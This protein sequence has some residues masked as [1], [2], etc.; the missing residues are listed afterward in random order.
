MSL[1]A[2]IHGKIFEIHGWSCIEWLAQKR[3]SR[4]HVFLTWS[5]KDIP[6]SKEDIKKT[7]EERI[8]LEIAYIISE[9]SCKDGRSHFHML[10]TSV[11]GSFDLQDKSR[12]DMY[13][14]GKRYSPYIVS[15]KSSADAR[16]VIY[17]LQKEDKTPL[18]KIYTSA[19][20]KCK[21]KSN[22]S[23]SS[24]GRLSALETLSI[25]SESETYGDVL[26]RIGDRA[27]PASLLPTFDRL[28]LEKDSC[29]LSITREPLRPIDEFYVPNVVKRWYKWWVTDQHAAGNGRSKC[30]IITGPPETAKTT[31]LRSLGPHL[32]FSS[33]VT[34]QDFQ[35]ETIIPEEIEYIVIDD[36]SGIFKS[37]N[38]YA[39][40]AKP[41]LNS[42]IDGFRAHLRNLTNVPCL[43]KLPVIWVQNCNKTTYKFWEERDPLD[44]KV[45]ATYVECV[46]VKRDVYKAVNKGF[47]EATSFKD[48]GGTA[49]LNEVIMRRARDDKIDTLE[50]IYGPYK[51]ELSDFYSFSK[52]TRK[53]RVQT[54]ADEHKISYEY[55]VE[56]IY[57]GIDINDFGVFVQ[58]ESVP[59]ELPEEEWN[60]I[61]DEYYYR[62]LNRNERIKGA[63]K[64]MKMTAE[65]IIE[66]MNESK[67]MEYL[68]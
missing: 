4:K 15:P 13:S 33:R 52:E 35:L 14:D 54:Y 64:A 34:L 51:R 31:M 50:S 23:C 47:L 61:C 42:K 32:Y 48:K 44:W 17:Y 5:H 24:V 3:F 37:D 68:K 25:C 65:E 60:K 12:F 49:V 27:V 40:F 10:M 8:K 67:T 2:S 1:P 46:P 39:C 22:N 20:G 18:Y 57:G 66:S 56:E 9:E 28:Q 6:F 59:N 19:D 21:K 58:W 45:G 41:L 55:A 16:H 11:N 43:N 26:N 62:D 38:S 30:L 36:A 53:R 7:M 29:P 63:D